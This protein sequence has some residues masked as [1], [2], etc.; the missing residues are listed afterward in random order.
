M[1]DDQKPEVEQPEDE[2]LTLPEITP[3]MN[4]RLKSCFDHGKRMTS[5]D[6]PDFDYANTMFTECVIKDPANV[7]YLEAFF[8]NL[9]RKY[10]NNKK[11]ARIK[12]YG[13]SKAAFKKSVAKKNW[14]E[15]LQ[16]GPELL[17]VNPWDN[18]TLRAMAQACEQFR[19][20]LN[21]AELKY[22]R[23]ALD[24]NSRDVETNKH[25]ARSLARMSQ[26]DGA[27]ACW[28]RVEEVKK[29]D[30]EAQK[31]IA[32]LMM[33]KTRPQVGMDDDDLS[34]DEKAK[35]RRERAEAAAAAADKAREEEAREKAAKKAAEEKSLEKEERR[36]KA[37]QLTPR[38]R[39]EKAIGDNALDIDNYIELCKLHEKEGRPNDVKT[40][41]QRAVSA[42]KGDMHAQEK[43][44]A[45]ETQDTRQKAAAAEKQ[46]REE[47]SAEA[48]KRA[49]Q[50][51]AEL[52]RQELAIFS[53]RAE[54]FT[55]QPALKYEVGIR[56][57]KLG[58]YDEAINNFEHAEKEPE[59]LA[60]ALIMKGECQQQNKLF[61]KA[62]ETFKTAVDEARAAR[63]VEYRKRAMWRAARL[64]EGL[65]QI[66]SAEKYYQMLYEFDPDYEDVRARLDRIRKIRDSGG[67][68]S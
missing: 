36:R 51:A 44:V 68:G 45:Y 61:Q 53:E 48:V 41:I 8:D 28:R 46:A 3:A 65:K 43:L 34:E 56:L 2:S 31:S 25:C 63:D 49:K 12:V 47:K 64:S 21:D 17:K 13:S 29:N 52:C 60:R 22:L 55:E 18:P 1:S 32:K 38:Q 24:A 57:K 59:L 27:I 11:G 5:Q 39:L 16:I 26:F 50:R 30:P 9:T 66:I 54:R 35:R 10:N 20:V 62:L 40:T 67:L 42:V 19:P 4:R 6:R 7:Q 58:K 14:Q 37:F 23:M 15:V 33:D